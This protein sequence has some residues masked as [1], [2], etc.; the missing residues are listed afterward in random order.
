MES[1]FRQRQQPVSAAAPSLSGGVPALQLD[2]PA[3]EIV[4]APRWRQEKKDCRG[5]TARQ[6]SCQAGQARSQETCQVGINCCGHCWKAFAW[7][8][9]VDCEAGKGDAKGSAAQRAS[10]PCH[11][12]AG[13]T[14]CPIDWLRQKFV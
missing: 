11:N 3:A 13:D 4:K 5:E 12:R 6:R 8:A 9:K 10:A 2:L 14:C 7:I 1:D